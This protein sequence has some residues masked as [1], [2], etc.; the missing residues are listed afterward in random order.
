MEP[1][2]MPVTVQAE[3]WE[4]NLSIELSTV[5][6]NSAAEGAATFRLTI[7]QRHVQGSRAAPQMRGALGAPRGGRA[8]HPRSVPVT[9]VRPSGI[10]CACMPSPARRTPLYDSLQLPVTVSSELGPNPRARLNP[11]TLAFLGDAVWEVGRAWH[12]HF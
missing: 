9:S 1:L 5:V 11:A 12:V 2:V 7:S 6:L 3:H 10:K 4:C 8:L